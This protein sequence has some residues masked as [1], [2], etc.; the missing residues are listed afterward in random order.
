MLTA[1]ALNVVCA[2]SRASPTRR[3]APTSPA[4]GEVSKRVKHVK[5]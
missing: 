5:Q 4:R 3:C 1:T 2:L